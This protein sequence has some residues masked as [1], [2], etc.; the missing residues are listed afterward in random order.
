MDGVVKNEERTVAL[1]KQLA[2]TFIVRGAQLAVVRRLDG[3]CVVQIHKDLLREAVK[4]V[5]ACD[6]AQGQGS[7]NRKRLT[8]TVAFFRGMV[9]LLKGVENRDALAMYVLCSTV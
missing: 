1:A 8:V 2:T 3:R 4:R 5:S 7:K 9:P 6:K